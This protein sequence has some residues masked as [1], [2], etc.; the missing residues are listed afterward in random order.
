MI[1]DDDRT[2][3]RLLKTLLEMDGFDVTIAATAAEVLSLAPQIQPDLFFMD[4]HLED[5]NGAEVTSVIRAT[6]HFRT[7]PIVIASGMNVEDEV[8]EAGASC[9]LMKPFDPSK[10]QQ[11]FH[12]LI[13]N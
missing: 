3:V 9:F 12:D 1:V 10:L 6:S 11:L 13:D 7:T 2:T 4:Y 8:R 5:S